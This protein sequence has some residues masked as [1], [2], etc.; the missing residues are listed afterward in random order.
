VNRVLMK[1]TRLGRV[2]GVSVALLYAAFSL[3]DMI[4]SLTAFAHGVPEGNPVM[5]WLLGRH[6][7]V[8]GKVFL[9]FLVS[10]LIAVLYRRS[11]V[12]SAAWVALS[13]M[14]A[15]DIYHF[16]GLRGI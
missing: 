12:R 10:G 14:I 4:L 8:P 15:V 13:L 5:S 7:F 2:S 11:Q 3:A 1:L 6:L 16:W 9:T